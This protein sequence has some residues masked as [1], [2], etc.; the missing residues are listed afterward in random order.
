MLHKKLS[1]LIIAFLGLAKNSIACI[2][3]ILFTL[4]LPFSFYLFVGPF[5]S[6][7]VCKL[8]R[9]YWILLLCHL[10]SNIPSTWAP[11]L[12]DGRPAARLDENWPKRLPIQK[13]GSQSGA[14]FA[15]LVSN[16]ATHLTAIS[17][18]LLYSLLCKVCN[19]YF[20]FL[21]LFFF[22]DPAKWPPK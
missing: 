4:F 12:L 17:V 11:T 6:R 5:F 19:Y 10:F 13:L 1:H 8:N 22:I 15:K 18:Y 14:S 2:I 9:L 20:Y 3:C 21:F 7:F 16:R